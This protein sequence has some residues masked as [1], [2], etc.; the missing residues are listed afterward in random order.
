MK[1]SMLLLALCLI[2]KF[3]FTLSKQKNDNL[4]IITFIIVV[5]IDF[6]L[7]LIIVETCLL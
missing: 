3:I 6:I 4:V 2:R 1:N 7:F 5:F